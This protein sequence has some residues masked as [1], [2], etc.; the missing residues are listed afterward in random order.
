[1]IV[2]SP[3]FALRKIRALCVDSLPA[4]GIPIAVG[5]AVLALTSYGYLAIASRALDA[6]AFA[7]IAVLWSI[8]FT[9]GPGIFA[10]LEME[11][12]RLVAGRRSSTQVGASG[13]Q[14]QMMVI[15]VLMA[16]AVTLL[17][18]FSGPLYVERFF[19]GAWVFVLAIAVSA[20]TFA[21]VYVL[22]GRLLG[23]QKF[24]RYGAALAAEGFGRVAGASVLMGALGGTPGAYAVILVCAPVFSLP[25]FLFSHGPR[26]AL[27][28]RESASAVGLLVTATL[29]GQ[30]LLNAGPIAVKLL[31]TEADAAVAGLFLSGLI[32]A[33]APIFVFAAIQPALL[34][35][36]SLL[37][38]DGDGAALS[39]VIG[40]ISW[41]VVW[42]G[43]VASVL[44]VAFG[45][46]VVTL[47]FGG[48]A[49]LS[50]RVMGLLFAT[51]LL[52]V[53]ALLCSQAIVA[54]SGHRELAGAWTSG[55]VGFVALLFFGEDLLVR[56][57]LALFVGTGI[58]AGY[59]GLL[60][61]RRLRNFINAARA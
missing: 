7:Q 58:T 61:R 28:V 10:P 45:P 19:D 38:R 5:V 52:Y 27:V 6:V 39:D 22:R 31:A 47:L 51:A 48:S 16:A 41:T 49:I 54:L 20:P 17:V 56:V 60:L 46:R 33:R 40:R 37:V 1:M 4:G 13:V 43:G 18:L 42:A 34:P 21:V 8:V 44:A 55:V 15:A 57:S 9:L 53:L 14:G 29:L 59:M 12:S 30:L 25:F 35:R 32:V 36:L 11:T 2:P 23:Q 26:A 3:R 24:G 50:G